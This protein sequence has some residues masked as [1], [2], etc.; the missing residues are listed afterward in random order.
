[1]CNLECRTCDEIDL[2]DHV[3]HPPVCMLLFVRKVTFLD[4]VDIRGWFSV[5]SGGTLFNPIFTSFW[6]Q[7][8]AYLRPFRHRILCGFITPSQTHAAGAQV[9]LP[10]SRSGL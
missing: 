6:R 2:L 9:S 7:S 10:R 5:G 3:A 8:E 1:M 4:T